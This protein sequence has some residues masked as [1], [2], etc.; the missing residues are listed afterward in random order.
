MSGKMQLRDVVDLEMMYGDDPEALVYED[1]ES[2]PVDS[3]EKVVAELEK[4]ENLDDIDEDLEDDMDL[5]DAVDD[6]DGA[7][8]DEDAADID[9]ESDVDP[10]DGGEHLD[11]ARRRPW[12]VILPLPSPPWKRRCGN[13]CWK[14]LPKSPAIMTI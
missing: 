10:A 13:R 2:T 5:E 14:F 3:L 11:D 7:D 1:E 12:A 9:G 4:K 6:E 8:E